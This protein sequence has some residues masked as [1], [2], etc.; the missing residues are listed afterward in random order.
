MATRR[1]SDTTPLTIDVE[2]S[3]R[4]RYNEA[5]SGVVHLPWGNEGT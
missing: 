1:T 4:S 2:R 5:G 3:P